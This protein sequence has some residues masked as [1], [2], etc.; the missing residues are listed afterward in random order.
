M[1]EMMLR[2]LSL[3]F[4]LVLLLFSVTGHILQ[5]NGAH[6]S[7]SEATCAFHHGMDLPVSL[8]AFWNGTGNPLEPVLDD[9][10]ALTLSS[11]IPHPP[12]R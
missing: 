6:H 4:L 1:D 5:S 9:S 8:C 7:P 11:A 12:T 2:K 10:S 3:A